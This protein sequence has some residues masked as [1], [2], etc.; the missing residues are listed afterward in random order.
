M[1]DVVDQRLSDLG[2][3]FRRAHRDPEVLATTDLTPFQARALVFV[4]R[5][6]G[7]RQQ[8]FVDRT[9][10]DKGQVARAYKCLEERGLI[11][12]VPDPRDRRASTVHLTAAG[13]L[14]AEQLVEHR[15]SVTERMLADFTS[16]ERE[17]L[18]ELLGRALA[19]LAAAPPA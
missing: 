7:S 18:V 12:R 9:G 16:E 4:A 3:K 15:R 5:F 10:R 14:T 1:I 11:E 8:R 6:P 13:A 17:T 2:H 19:G